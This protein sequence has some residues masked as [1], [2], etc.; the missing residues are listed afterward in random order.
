VLAP[1]ALAVCVGGFFFTR[2]FLRE[3]RD[4]IDPGPH[5]LQVDGRC[6]LNAG[7]AALQGTITNTDDHDHDYRIVVR[8]TSPADSQRE[9]VGVRDVRAGATAHWRVTTAIEGTPVACAVDDVYGPFP[10]DVDG[11]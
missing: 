5:Q 2:A 6:E 3:L 1:I 8:F 4:Y 11:A 10:F 9:A 7:V